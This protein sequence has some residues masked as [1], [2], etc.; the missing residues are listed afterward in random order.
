MNSIFNNVQL[1]LRNAYKGQIDACSILNQG[2]IIDEKISSILNGKLPHK[3]KNSMW[4]SLFDI[5]TFTV[6]SSV[7]LFHINLCV[8]IHEIWRWNLTHLFEFIIGQV[9]TDDLERDWPQHQGVFL[10]YPILLFIL[11]LLLTTE[12]SKCN[13]TRILNMYTFVDVSWK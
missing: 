10:K 11:I 2:K 5:T 1:C 4:Q 7:W 9:L 13:N 12:N 3:D 8:D 6:S